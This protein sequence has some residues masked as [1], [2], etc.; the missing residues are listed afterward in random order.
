MGALEASFGTAPVLTAAFDSGAAAAGLSAA[1]EG[2]FA[3]R[4][5]ATFT[6]AVG[7]DGTLSWKMVRIY[8]EYGEILMESYFDGE[9][10]LY[11][12]DQYE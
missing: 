12:V 10:N 4:D 11:H 7:E 8:D 6:P 5:G 1:V 3:G 2:P 9:G